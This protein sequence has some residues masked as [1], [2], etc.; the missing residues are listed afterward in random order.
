MQKQDFLNYITKIGSCESEVDRRELLAQ[1]GEEAS[2]DYDDFATLTETNK[3]LTADNETLRNANMK[4]FL[5][6]GGAKE[7]Q[8]NGHDNP[9]NNDTN[10]TYENLFNEKG[11]LK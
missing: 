5:R 10:L 3:T 1:L 9:Q 4:L 7:E 8:P 11:E 2:K 6:V